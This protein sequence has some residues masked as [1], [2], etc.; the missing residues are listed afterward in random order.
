MTISDEDLARLTANEPGPSTPPA[1]HDILTDK[2]LG[3]T[4]LRDHGRDI[5]YCDLWRKWL[6]WEGGRWKPDDLRRTEHLARATALRRLLQDAAQID[7]DKQRNH[8][9][10]D[11]IAAEGMS[12]IEGSLHAASSEPAL[13]I[14]PDQLDANPWLLLPPTQPSTSK[15]AKPKPP[16]A[17]RP[18]NQ[19][20]PLPPRPRPPAPPPGTGFP[21]TSHPRPRH[22]PLPPTRLR[23]Q[24]G[25][26][27]N[28]AKIL[29]I[30]WGQG[31]NGK[32]TFLPPNNPQ[33]PRRLQPTSTPET[34]LAKLRTASPTDI[35]RLRESARFVAAVQR[36]RRR[37]PPQRN[38]HQKHE[39]AADTMT[40]RFLRQEYFQIRRPQFTPWLATNHKP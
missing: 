3:E 8:H 18:H 35:A 24:H 19:T 23:L 13:A 25:R 39:P 29:L 16:N 9:A 14:S 6:L 27:H 30:L 15:P 10:K 26:R 1:T 7:D 5:R 2:A 12:R 11:I 37:P 40:A 4:I 31:S 38:P 20:S 21:R 33:A 17:L 34:F 32:S 36:N 22:P 28:P